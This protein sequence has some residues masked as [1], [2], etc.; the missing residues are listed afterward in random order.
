MQHHQHAA[1]AEWI[2]RLALDDFY[3]AAPADTKSKL[4]LERQ[5]IAGATLY[6]ARN[7]R[8]TLLNRVV[9]FGI[10]RTGS[11]ADLQAITSHYRNAGSQDYLLQVQPWVR[12][13]ETWNWLFDA[14]L[15]RN[16]GWTQFVRTAGPVASIPTELRVVR[17]GRE[18]AERFARIVAPAFD[19]SDRAI[20][21]LAAMVGLRGWYH[22]MSF[23]GDIPAGAGALRVANGIGW[24]DWGA[25]S[26]EYRG[27]GSQSAI[28]A[29][30]IRSAATLGCRVLY[31]ETG[32]AVPGDPQ[33]SF[34]NLVK[35]G[36]SP[37]HTRE[38]F[39]P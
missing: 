16:R 29:E 33:H 5:E 35:V 4:G 7:E 27:R 13:V 26:P 19:L 32:E 36:F 17:I 18:D 11:M 8:N 28:L 2:E 30:R 39:A 34:R 14:G 12:P 10:D 1:A 15:A 24:L 6:A 31:S 3:Q 9:G 25:T 20:P 21:A 22:F 38:N 23:D 37:S